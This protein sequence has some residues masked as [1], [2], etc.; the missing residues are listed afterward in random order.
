MCGMRCACEVHLRIPAVQKFATPF[1]KF[2]KPQG[3]L[4]VQI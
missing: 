1:Q 2:A 3:R 4:A